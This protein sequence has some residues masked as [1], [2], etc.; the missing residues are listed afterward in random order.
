[1]GALCEKEGETCLLSPESSV[2]E[3]CVGVGGRDENDEDRADCE[4]EKEKL[5]RVSSTGPPLDSTAR[6][7]GDDAAAEDGSVEC[8]EGWRANWSL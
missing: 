4:D 2:K 8:D 6:P 5:K 3:G 7:E 1:M